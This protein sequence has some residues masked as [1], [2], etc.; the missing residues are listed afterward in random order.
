MRSLKVSE[1]DKFKPF[2][3]GEAGGNKKAVFFI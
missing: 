1:V 3:T 2:F